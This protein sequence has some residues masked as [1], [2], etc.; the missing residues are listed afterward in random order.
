MIAAATGPIMAGQLRHHLAWTPASLAADLIAAA[1]RVELIRAENRSVAAALD[2]SYR[3]L[4]ARQRRMFRRLGHHPGPDLDAYA[5]ALDGTTLAA[6]RRCL[7]ALYDRHLVTEP[8]PGRFLLHDLL[9]AGA[10]SLAAADD[11]AAAE[12]AAAR[13]LDYYTHT[14]LAAAKHRF[15][16]C[17]SRCVAG[18]SPWWKLP[19]WATRAPAPR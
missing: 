14:A 5:A 16:K 19:T 2:L 4:T 6:A 3:S 12:A 17:P 15:P 7:H 13:L 10:Q 11:A 1:D 9:R 8:V 18:P